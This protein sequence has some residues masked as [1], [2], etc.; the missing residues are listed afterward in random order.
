MAVDTTAEVT[1]GATL[2]GKAQPATIS[3]HA[4][5]P[6]AVAMEKAADCRMAETVSRAAHIPPQHATETEVK[7]LAASIRHHRVAAETPRF[8]IAPE[9]AQ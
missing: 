7:V 9:A 2:V 8:L 4:L 5:L 3:D 1:I 6:T